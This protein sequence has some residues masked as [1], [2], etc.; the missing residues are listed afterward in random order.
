MSDPSTA[1]RIDSTR[2]GERYCDHLFETYKLFVQSTESVSNR[3]QTA[4]SFFLTLNSSIVA[5][6]SY[7]IS[8]GTSAS[9]LVIPIVG[10]LIGYVWYRLIKSYRDLNSAKFKVI[11]EIEQRL[12]LAVFDAEW[13]YLGRGDDSKKYLR[14]TLIERA[15]PTIFMVI[16]VVVLIWN[17][18]NRNIC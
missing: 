13:F 15:I 5:L 12:P 18:I 9:S 10:I 7:L 4:N 14:F 6:G 16:H 1:F 2:Y 11:H 3:R 8:C 17:I